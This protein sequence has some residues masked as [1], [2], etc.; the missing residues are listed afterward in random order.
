MPHTKAAL[1]NKFDEWE[2][3]LGALKLPAWSA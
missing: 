3:Y 2:S 1:A